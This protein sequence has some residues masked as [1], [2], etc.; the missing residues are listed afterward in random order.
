MSFW[1]PLHQAVYNRASLE[2][3]EKMLHAGAF[4]QY[5]NSTAPKCQTYWSEAGTLRT[6]WT[7]FSYL[8]MTPLELAQDLGY[9]ELYAVLAPI[10]RWSVPAATLSSLQRRFHAIIYT[11]L[12]DCVESE[13]MYLPELVVLTELAIPQMWFPIKG[14]KISPAVSL[15]WCQSHPSSLTLG[16]VM[17]T[18]WTVAS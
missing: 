15:T 18:A 2:V 1:T 6:R 16:R 4:R 13:H 5:L 11:D 12:G 10:L 8:D 3:V 17:F 14:T 9:S 7:K